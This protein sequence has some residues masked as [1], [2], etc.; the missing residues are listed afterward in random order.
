[1]VMF[2][3]QDPPQVSL[4]LGSTL[5]P[6]DIKEGDDVYFECNIRANPKQHKITWFHDV[7][8]FLTFSKRNLVCALSCALPPK[9]LTSPL[10]VSGPPDYSGLNV[11]GFVLA[12]AD[13]LI[14]WIL[15][16]PN[17]LRTR[18]RCDRKPPSVLDRASLY[19]CTSKGRKW[20]ILIKCSKK[21][22]L[23]CMV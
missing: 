21:I 1:M 20:L 15:K 11:S 7:S 3:V 12:A 6:E 16:V 8:E 10:S 5:N 23:Y 17:S 4:H 14:I 19:W 22:F 9:D 2:F 18:C 13:Y